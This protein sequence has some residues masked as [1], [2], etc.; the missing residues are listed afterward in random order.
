MAADELVGR[1]AAVARLRAAVDSAAAGRG[2]LV[3]V[4]GEAGIGKTALVSRVVERVAAGDAQVLWATCWDGPGAP[5]YW[6]WVQVVR[7]HVR[8]CD[9][10]TLRAQLGAGAGEVAR[11]IG[12][13]GVLAGEWSLPSVAGIGIRIGPGSVCSTR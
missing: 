12:E 4:A 5:A 11:L 9:P 7:S 10:A 2:G 1:D 6:P 13:P 3:L 8:A